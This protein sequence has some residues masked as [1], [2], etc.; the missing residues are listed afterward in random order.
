MFL[1]TKQSQRKQSQETRDFYPVVRPSDT[2]L[3]PRCGVPMDKGCTQPLS[4]DSMINLNTTAFFLIV[5]PICE[6]SPQVGASRPYNKDHKEG[7][8]VRLGE[9]HTQHTNLQRTHAHK[10]KLELE[11]KHR[12]FTTRTE[13]KSLTQSI[14][15]AEAECGSLRMLSE[16]LG[17]LHHAPR[18]PLIA[19]RQLGAVGGKLGRPSL[20]SVEWRTGQSGAPPDSYCNLSVVR[21]PSKSGTDDRCSSGP[22]GA[23][24][25]V[26][27]TLDS[28]VPPADRWSCHASPADFATDHWRWRPLAHRTVQCT[29]RQSGEL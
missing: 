7:T 5:F 12:E 29:T 26:R 28:P 6:E 2:C 10:S 25:T 15:C 11:T 13:L 3:L 18:V 21:L 17:F 9:Q 19:P 22:V 4:S 20:P 16:C 14:K 24:D 27:C 1:W 8:R 23:P